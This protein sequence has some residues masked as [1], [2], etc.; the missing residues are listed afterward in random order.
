M[1]GAR[2]GALLRD[3]LSRIALTRFLS[4][5]LERDSPS[6]TRCTTWLAP[7]SERLK[8]LWCLY[9]NQNCPIVA[10]QSSHLHLRPKLTGR[11]S[12]KM[13]SISDD[14]KH[15]A[16]GRAM[17][18]AHFS[19]AKGY[20]PLNHGSYGASPICVRQCQQELQDEA[21]AR[22]DLFLRRKLPQLLDES[23][24]AIVPMLGVPLDEIVFVPNATTAVNTVLRNLE[25]G[26]RE[27]IIYFSTIYDACEKTVQYVC[28]STAAQSLRVELALPL[29]DAEIIAQF[30][31]AVL[32]VRKAG[33]R[34]KIAL[35][36]TVLTFPGVKMPWE[37]LVESCKKHKILSLID[38]AHGIGH[39]DLTALGTV[40]PDFFTSNCYK[41][42]YT[43][44]GSAI[45]YVPKRN[46]H[47]IRSTLPTSHGF[48]PLPNQFEQLSAE[49][50]QSTRFVDM[51]AF[52]GTKE[53]SPFVC[54]PKAIEFR[55]KVCGGEAKIRR[56]CTDLAQQGGQ[57]VADIL[58]TRTMKTHS[59]RTL[60]E[61]CFATIQL[62]L[63]FK[64]PGQDDSPGKTVFEVNQWPK[65]SKFIKDK[66]EIEHDTFIPVSYHAG[67][68]WA[69]ISAQIYL[70]MD[71]FAFAGMVLKQLCDK[72][73]QGEH[74]SMS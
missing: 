50:G 13:V 36:D 48:L 10:H 41:W 26:E 6:H 39:I 40:Q 49:A 70:D 23:R 21:E 57:R 52:V 25:Y 34:V 68:M 46:Q 60:Q 2:P 37:K 43:P 20:T 54:V 4:L 33:K 24:A 17:R 38:G 64:T 32:G 59:D 1:E 15:V 74:E 8:S 11:Q 58:G 12:A 28:E 56:Y 31:N 71:D 45:F 35:F 66:A 7:E 63:R 44:R 67:H 61:C 72:V 3:P 22:P 47:L 16:F 30:E 27:V 19:Y 51:F 65:I 69:R 29:G 9:A 14:M 73:E 62:P 53:M 55:E 18:E 5:L 42:L